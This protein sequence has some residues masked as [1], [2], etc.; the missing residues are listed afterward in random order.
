MINRSIAIVFVLYL[1]T[2]SLIFLETNIFIFF[3]SSTFL[4]SSNIRGLYFGFPG[5]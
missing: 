1:F 3:F 2:N 4:I 5:S